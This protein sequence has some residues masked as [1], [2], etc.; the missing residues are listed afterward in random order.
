MNISAQLLLGAMVNV[1]SGAT[2]NIHKAPTLPNHLDPSTCPPSYTQH[3]L[4]LLSMDGFR[5]DFLSRG[6]T[7][8]LQALAD[9]GVTAPYMKPSYPTITFPNHYTIVTGLFPPSH[10]II[11]NKFYD[12]Q[13]QAE[14]RLGRPESFK[15]RWWGGE[16]IWK[17]VEKQGKV[18]ATYFWPGS[19][20]DGL[21][22]TYWYHYNES[23]PY[24][25]RVNKV[26]SWL[27]LP[28]ESRPSFITLYMHDPDS[29]GHDFGAN[30][31]QLDEILVK[32]DSM[33]KLLIEGLKA[34]SLLAC[35]NL[36]LVADHGL[37]NTGSEKVINLDQYIPNIMNA[38][39]RFWDGTFS[40]FEPNDKSKSTKYEMMNALSCKQPEMRVYEREL[41]PIRWHMGRQRRLEGVVLDVDPGNAVGSPQYKSDLG[42]H[43]YDNYFSTMNALFVAHGPDLKQKTEVEAFQNVELYNLMCDLLGVQPAPNNGTQ[44]ALH[45]LLASPSPSLPPHPPNLELKVE[46]VPYEMKEMEQRLTM[47]N[48]EGD[49]DEH[50]KLLDSLREASNDPA[51]ISRHLPWGLDT[52]ASN[53]SLLL[54][55]Q[56]QFVSAYSPELKH[57]LWTSFS[58]ENVN[59]EG[60]CEG[61]HCPKWR[62]DVR[63]RP[64]HSATCPS[65]TSVAAYNISRHPLFP[66]VFSH[67][68]H[69]QLPFLLS[70]A[71]PFSNQLKGRWQELMDFIVKWQQLYGP[72]N[73]ITGPVFDFDA[74]SLADDITT[75]SVNKGVVVPTH[76]FLVVS[77][78]V[79]WVSSLKN[80]P[81]NLIDTLAF[82]YPQYLPVTNCLDNARFAQEF[83]ARVRDVEL[84]TGF[85]FYPHLSSQDRVRLQVRIHS[86]IWGRETWHNRLRNNIIHHED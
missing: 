82:V 68:E 75:L 62:S 48:C 57:P 71:L 14:F 58:I 15:R 83:S 74:D 24:E 26:L 20:V 76:M 6:L 18:A 47:A 60:K 80:C 72:L 33:V 64:Q 3:P 79:V 39:T 55:T 51:L 84:I 38:T 86:N 63:L 29:T 81:H 85:K 36:L 43:G 56:P 78:C 37:V 11:A 40:R 25:H 17:T 53:T 67:D 41:L 65:F 2:I 44:G 66:P 4:V 42:D 34:R 10:G 30:S 23:I 12:P 8:T 49:K 31:P 70:N 46:R 32:V 16:P 28:V 7:P 52:H 61:E 13:F 22:P 21:K 1:L 45:H 5:A 19:E 35:V 54:L 77:R 50:R 59:R 73:V 27:D 9:N 69:K